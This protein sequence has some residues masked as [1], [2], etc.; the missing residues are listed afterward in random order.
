ME[1]YHS[2][3][4]LPN[5]CG[6]SLVQNIDAPLPL[7]WS[8]LRQFDN[9]QAYKQFVRSCTMRAGDGGIGSIREV[10]VS[11]CLPA[12]TSMERLDKLDDDKHVLDFSIVGGEHKLVNYSSTTTVQEKARKTVVTQSYVVDAPAGSSI[13]DACLFANTIIECNL[14]SL[15]KVTERMAAN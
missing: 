5:P 3:A 1:S 7:A 2:H 4:L 8:I 12:K 9:P 6:S 13:V 15:A 11:T 14:R 10:M